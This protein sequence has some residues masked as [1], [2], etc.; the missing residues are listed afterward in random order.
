MIPVVSLCV[1]G[2]FALMLVLVPVLVL[3]YMLFYD[4]DHAISAKSHQ[5]FYETNHAQLLAA[6]RDVMAHPEVYGTDNYGTDNINGDSKPQKKA[7]PKVIADLKPAYW[8][9]NNKCMLIALTCGFHHSGTTALAEGVKLSDE[10]VFGFPLRFELVPGLW[11]TEDE[12]KIR[13]TRYPPGKEYL[14]Y[15]DRDE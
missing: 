12:G 7:V 2:V 6:C 1:S 8:T 5:L 3:A 4:W 14:K 11:F 10:N 15:P 13:T 9:A